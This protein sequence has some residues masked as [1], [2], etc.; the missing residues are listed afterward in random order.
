MNRLQKLAGLCAL[1]GALSGV[2]A[3]AEVQVNG[4]WARETI[5]GT[6]SSALFATI[7][8]GNST[9][10]ALV[11]VT[12]QGVEKAELHTSTEQGGMM[13]MRRV[14]RIELDA[15]QAV[16]LAPGGYHVMLFRLSEPLL[17]GSRLPAQFEFSN[18]EKVSAEV[19]VKSAN[20]DHAHHHH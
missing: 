19:E 17:A 5:P 9:A 6:S 3:L 11:A 16:E 18:G 13:R 1:I 7:N 4:A 20:D 10:V 8:N 14:E 15:G 12:V 2:Q